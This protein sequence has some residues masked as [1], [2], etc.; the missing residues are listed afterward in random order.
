MNQADFSAIFDVFSSSGLDIRTS[1]KNKTFKELNCQLNT[2]LGYSVGGGEARYVLAT[3]TLPRNCEICNQRS[4][5][6][7]STLGYQ[8]TC[9][10]SCSRKLDSFLSAITAP[11]VVAKRV[12]SNRQTLAKMGVV[13]IGQLDAVKQKI[14][15]TN[16]QRYGVKNILLQ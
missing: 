14:K 5:F 13:N 4:V 10:I 16:Q 3:R 12:T 15:N 2:L 8:R 1:T 7:G 6:R 11:E 9:S